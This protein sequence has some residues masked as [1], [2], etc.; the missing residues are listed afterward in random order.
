M[1]I[2]GQSTYHASYKGPKV[3]NINF[4]TLKLKNTH[5]SSK[6]KMEMMTS[7]NISYKYWT[8][9][10]NNSTIKKSY[11]DVI[12]HPVGHQTTYNYS[13]TEPGTYSDVAKVL[14][15]HEKLCIKKCCKNE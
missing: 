14:S 6:K 3:D 13:Y 2:E 4:K 8:N 15:E 1:P 5:V 11:N 9:S 7:N 10:L 12:K